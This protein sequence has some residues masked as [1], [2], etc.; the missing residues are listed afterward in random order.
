MTIVS[1][2]SQ[3]DL[4]GADRISVVRIL[5]GDQFNFE[6][7]F[8]DASNQPI[9]VSGWTHTAIA[10]GYTADVPSD[11]KPIKG[12]YQEQPGDVPRSMA[13]DLSDA[14]A[15]IVRYLFPGDI[16]PDPI[17]IDIEVSVPVF[18]CD[19]SYFNGAE[20]FT[21][22]RWNVVMKEAKKTA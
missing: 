15:G 13:V 20:G 14:A 8:L 11:G 12:T 9:D 10:A 1:S 2:P 22:E 18:V 21:F 3:T 17:E 6:S 4:G 16:H 19:F 7:T 5:R